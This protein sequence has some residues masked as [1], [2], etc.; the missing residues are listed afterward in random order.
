MEFSYTHIFFI[1]TTRRL[2]IAIYSNRGG[3][4][5]RVFFR[6]STYLIR[7]VFRVYKSIEIYYLI[8]LKG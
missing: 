7:V 6:F 8:K 4:R 1:F 3:K 5:I 2:N